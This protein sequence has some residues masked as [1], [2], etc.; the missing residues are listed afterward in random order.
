MAVLIVIGMI[1]K[2]TCTSVEMYA[3]AHT[4][5][6]VGHLGI[7]YIIT[8]ILAD[9]TSLRNRMILFGINNTPLIATTFA[10]P[11]IAELFY[12]NVNFR[13]AFGAFLIILVFFCIPVMLVFI[14]SKRKAVRRGIYPERPRTRNAWESFKY[15][16][17]QFDG[18]PKAQ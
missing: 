2:A 3:A 10:G 12:D 16:F 17:V 6:W 5:Y 4:L 18:K 11:K 8:I 1:M 13:W 9:I 14:F 15:Y 7:E